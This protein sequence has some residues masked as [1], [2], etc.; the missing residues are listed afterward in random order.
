ML[1]RV[2]APAQRIW[3][4]QINHPTVGA[5]LVHK[6]GHRLAIQ[7][8]K[9]V[10][11]RVMADSSDPWERAKELLEAGSSVEA[12]AAARR[13]L[14]GLS[15]RSLRRSYSAVGVALTADALTASRLRRP[16]PARAL[17]CAACRR[18]GGAVRKK[19]QGH[20]GDPCG[21]LPAG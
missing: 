15:E 3:D 18:K 10:Q 21:H 12:A 7:A 2:S 16:R 4:H 19:R 13:L 5:A 11:E 8:Q 6:T 20:H 17:M 9:K 14:Q 1:G